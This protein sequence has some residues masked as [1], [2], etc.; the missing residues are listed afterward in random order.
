MIQVK[1]TGTYYY[2][3]KTL[4]IMKTKNTRADDKHNRY[5]DKNLKKIRKGSN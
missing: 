2:G 4:V 3:R 5:Y 1:K